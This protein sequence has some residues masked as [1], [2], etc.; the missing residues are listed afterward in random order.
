MS[1]RRYEDS[2][3]AI[4][5]KIYESE[6]K[7]TI[8]AALPGR[9]WDGIKYVA[10]TRL[11]LSRRKIVNSLFRRH[12][13][14]PIIDALRKRRVQLG[15]HQGDVAKAAGYN[16]QTIERGES[17]RTDSQF[18]LIK[19]WAESLGFELR[20]YDTGNVKAKRMANV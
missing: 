16:T 14:C 19:S 5:L 9:T 15:L 10:K 11:K 6:S 12:S 2:E 20:L 4:M 18:T 13:E 3:L 7:E 17:R 8:L 1:G